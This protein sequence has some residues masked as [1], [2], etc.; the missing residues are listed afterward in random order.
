MSVILF[1]A[2]LHYNV[3]ITKYNFVFLCNFNK[4]MSDS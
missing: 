3:E 2:K 1:S 4:I